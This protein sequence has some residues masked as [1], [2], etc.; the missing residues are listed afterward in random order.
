MGARIPFFVPEKASYPLGRLFAGV[1]QPF[2]RLMPELGE[3]L[4]VLGIE[5]DEA[6]YTGAALVNALFAGV[7]LGAAFY[8]VA[9]RVGAAESIRVHGSLITGLAIFLMSLAYL[10]AFPVWVVRRRADEIE[11]NLLYAVRHI[12]VQTTAG[13]PFFEALSSAAS[14]Y[15]PVS[16][17]FR[18]IVNQVNGGK[19]LADALE[20]SAAKSA[21]KYYKRILWHV[22]NSTRSGYNIADI[23]KELVTYLAYEQQIRVKKFGSELNVMS[24]F[25]LSTCVILPTMGLILAVILSSFAVVSLSP[26]LLGVFVFVIAIFNLM[27]LGMVQSRR[28]RGLI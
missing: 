21:S 1:V 9:V 26:T 7:V 12:M 20:E 3:S 16:A 10:L 14:G 4:P 24:L 19:D 17:E 8:M 11:E 28:P 27:F 23:M 6:E 15:G 25:Y 18:N 2:T 5:H 13:V 22:A